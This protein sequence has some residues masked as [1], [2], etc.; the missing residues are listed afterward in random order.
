MHLLFKKYY[1]FRM[2]CRKPRLE[3]TLDIVNNST[4]SCLTKFY[5][6]KMNKSFTKDC[7]EIDIGE[8]RKR[9]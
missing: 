7:S 9:F 3:S 8:I 1:E 2:D 5:P 4:C 6:K